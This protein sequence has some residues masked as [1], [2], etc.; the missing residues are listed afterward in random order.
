MKEL[1]EMQVTVA[2]DVLKNLVEERG[3]RITQLIFNGEY[4]K[5]DEK[6]ALYDR[7]IKEAEGNYEEAVQR[8]NSCC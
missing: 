4:S 2:A 3:E 8:L 7:L 5:D 6:L 1:Y